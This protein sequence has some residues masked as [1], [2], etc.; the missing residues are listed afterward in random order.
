MH[1][2][3]VFLHVAA[4]I[5][6]LGAVM[7]GTSMFPRAALAAAR[8]DE[9]AKGSARTTHKMTT[10][11]GYLSALVPLFGA[12]L[13]FTDWSTYSSMPQYHTALLLS[14]IA[15]IVLFVVILPKQKKLAGLSGILPA[16]EMDPTETPT[17]DPEKLKKTLTISAGVFNLLW[18]VS[19]I[20]MYI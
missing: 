16:G 1:S 2:F 18:V 5:L 7:Y 12:T 20:M 4:A 13:M 3:L 17:G 19:L 15:W 14:A 9:A 10:T 11:Y 6:F 8:G